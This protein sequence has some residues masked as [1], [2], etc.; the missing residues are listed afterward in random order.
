MT[1]ELSTPLLTLPPREVR[2]RT[3][4]WQMGD[5]V[6]VG[7]KHWIIRVLTRDGRVE[8]A[9]ANAVNADIWW[10]TTI[11]KLPEKTA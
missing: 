7:T 4:R 1:V 3:P 8:L 9:S 11:D 6:L 10:R 5:T 2:K